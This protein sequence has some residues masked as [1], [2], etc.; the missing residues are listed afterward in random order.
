MNQHEQQVR[1]QSKAQVP[2]E[3]RAVLAILEA[4]VELKAKALSSVDLQK[5]EINWDEIFK[6]DF[7]SGHRAALIWAKALYVGRRPLR[8]DPFDRASAMDMNLRRAV[9]KAVEIQWGLGH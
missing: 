8:A 2:R 1:E 5:R 4:D 9:L 3:F 6:H 7:G